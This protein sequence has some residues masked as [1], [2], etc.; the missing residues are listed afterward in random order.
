MEPIYEAKAIRRFGAEVAN[1]I[2]FIIAD[3]NPGGLTAEQLCYEFER[4]V[5]SKLESLV[6]VEG[7]GFVRSTRVLCSYWQPVG[8]QLSLQCDDYDEWFFAV[9]PNESD[10]RTSYDDKYR[11]MLFIQAW[12]LIEANG[13]ISVQCENTGNTALHFLLAIPGAT[14]PNLVRLLLQAGGD[15]LALKMNKKQQNIL[16]VIAG[17]MRAEKN[18][19]GRFGVWKSENHMDC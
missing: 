5:G 2:L 19:N 1:E 9:D 8:N 12:K 15:K 7:Q 18:D 17:R 3:Q 4:R 16:H 11:E 6:G 10:R 13:L 14:T